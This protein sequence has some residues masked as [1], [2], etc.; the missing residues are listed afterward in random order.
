MNPL[1]S[2]KRYLTDSD[3]RWQFNAT[4]GLYNHVSDEKYLARKFKLSL[5]YD[6]DFKNPVTYNQKLQWIK[7]YDHD[8]EYTRMVDKYTAKDYARE[9]IGEEYIIPTLGVYERAEDIDFDALPKSF[10]LKCTHDSHGVVVVRDSAKMD[11]DKVRKTLAKGLKRNY[12]LKFREWPYKNVK[13]RIIAEEYKEET[14]VHQLRR[15]SGKIMGGTAKYEKEYLEPFL[16]AYPD[17]YDAT[18][19]LLPGHD[20]PSPIEATGSAAE[21][22]LAEANR[23]LFT[24]FP[25]LRGDF[26]PG[27]AN[28]WAGELTFYK[29][30]GF[31]EIL[32][33][34]P[35]KKN[36]WFPLPGGPKDTLIL[37]TDDVIL[38]YQKRQKEGTQEIPLK[39]YKVYTFNG[40]AK[41]LVIN[42]DRGIKTKGDYYDREGN[43]MDFT[44][45]FVHAN[46]P[47]E[48]PKNFE[49]M[50]DLAE[51]LA[52][53]KCELRVDFYEVNG[54]IYFGETTFFDGSGFDPIIPIELD[55]TFGSWVTLPDKKQS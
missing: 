2:L 44:W 38:T 55:Y 20:L 21:D 13:P 18:G 49:K 31:E 14:N 37:L 28:D 32:K 45:G 50:F 51:K 7:V 48:K 6:M 22:F 34:H 29:T 19:A 10:V 17:L 35:E 52:E 36:Q 26:Y 4:K 8:P 39:D 11:P 16:L 27:D 54:Q 15:A 33:A 3:Y 46:V 40:K 9:R 42:Q 12:Y 43:W 24:T 41:F 53:G 1:R 5:G 25:L 23:K 47:P 30:R